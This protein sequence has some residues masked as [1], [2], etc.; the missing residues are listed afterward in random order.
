MEKKIVK[1]IDFIVELE[2]MKSVFRK[3]KIIGERRFEDDAQHSWHVATMAMTL[4]EYCDIEISIDRVIRMLLVH[5]LVEIYA[6]DTFGYDTEG[7]K[8]KLERETRAADKLFGMLDDKKSIYFR[9]LWD[10]FEEEESNDALFALA[11][12]RLQPVLTNYHNKGGTWVEH[13]VRKSSIEKRILPIK[14]SSISIWEYAI[15]LLN[16]AVEKSY[17][18]E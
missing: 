9:D 5:D 8:D 17:I 12:D 15:D 3:T 2:K 13:N 10:E 7:Y 6:G 1:D 4:E 11:M 14:K 18:E 16:D